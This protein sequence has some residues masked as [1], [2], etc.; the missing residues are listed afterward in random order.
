MDHDLKMILG[1]IWAIILDFQIKGINVEE[2]TA[3]EGLLLWCQKRTAGYEKVKITDFTGSWQ[4]GLGFCALIHRHRPDLLD[5]NSLDKENPAQNLELAFS[6]AENQLGIPRLLD[7]EDILNVPRPDERSVMT[8]VSEYFH[9]FASLGNKEMAARRVQKFAL[10][11]KT[12]EQLEQDYEQKTQQLLNWIFATVEKLN[13][14]NFGETIQEAQAA[15]EGYKSFLSKEKPTKATD[16]LDLE[17]SFVDIQTRLKVYSRNEY[18]APKD[19]TPDDLDDAWDLLEN[20]AK[21]RAKALRNNLFKFITK[22]ASGI[23][24]E[25]RKEFESSFA[26]F[27]KDGSGWLDR[28]EFKAALSALSIP[29]KDENAFNLL[30][31]K[32]SGGNSKISKEQFMAYMTEMTEDKDTPEQI[33]EAFASLADGAGTISRPQMRVHPLKDEVEIA[34]LAARMPPSSGS[35]SYDYKDYVN[36]SYASV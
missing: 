16:K 22:I 9:C 20:A 17:A 6:I 23:T 10:F 29:F 34:F 1:M 12:M 19:L 28:T 3:K 7:I 2:M 31:H 36:S 24:E 18:K 4:S 27:D 8:Y 32:V 33:K 26:H 25:Q 35:E 5:Y 30:F 11:N 13:D 21:M 15:F 14:R